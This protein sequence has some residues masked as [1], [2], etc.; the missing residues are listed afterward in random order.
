MQVQTM[1]VHGMFENEAAPTLDSAYV[2]FECDLIAI[3]L[4]THAFIEGH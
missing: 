4:P 3:G 2:V 1:N